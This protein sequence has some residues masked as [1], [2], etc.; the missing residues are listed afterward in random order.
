MRQLRAMG[1]RLAII[2]TIAAAGVILWA[3]QRAGEAILR[4][5]ASRAP[6]GERWHLRPG[7]YRGP[8]VEEVIRI[9]DGRADSTPADIVE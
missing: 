8:T 6:Y 1:A 4:P 3:A 7:E 9:L 2:G 5:A